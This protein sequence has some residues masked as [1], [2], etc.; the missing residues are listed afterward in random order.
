LPGNGRRPIA[1]RV[2]TGCFVARRRARNLLDLAGNRIQPRMDIV[3]GAAFLP[4]GILRL[5]MGIAEIRWGGFADSGIE[6]V[7]QRHA[8][9]ARG[10]LGPLA[11]GWIDAVNTPRYAR[12]HDLVR[13]RIQRFTCA[14]SFPARPG[15]ETIEFGAGRLPQF[16]TFSRYGK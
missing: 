16:L 4:V 11:K 5:G 15:E 12:I 1:W 6:P 7:V 8:G 3:D 14:F 2:A 10:A 9:A 13:F